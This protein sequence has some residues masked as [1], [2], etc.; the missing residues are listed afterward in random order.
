MLNIM[1]SLNSPRKNKFSVKLFWFT[2]LFLFVFYDQVKS[3]NVQGNRIFKVYEMA[4]GLY[5]M[6][7]CYVIKAKVSQSGHCAANEV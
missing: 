5:C 4:Q 2:G 6:T 7:S 1:S 3:L